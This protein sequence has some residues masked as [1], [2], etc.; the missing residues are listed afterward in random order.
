MQDGYLAIVYLPVVVSCVLFALFLYFYRQV[1]KPY[2]RCWLVAWGAYTVHAALRVWEFYLNFSGPGMMPLFIASSLALVLM[3]AC[4]LRAA[5]EI[6]LGVGKA[7]ILLTVLGAGMLVVARDV[8]THYSAGVLNLLA[9]N[10]PSTLVGTYAGLLM[11]AAAGYLFWAARKQSSL[12]LVGLGSALSLWALLLTSTQ[13]LIGMSLGDLIRQ[14]GH[15]LGALP[16]MLVGLA[17]IVILFE[18]QRRDVLA[19]AE[20]FSSLRY[21]P[22]PAAVD[23]LGGSL[24]R[25]LGRFLD[26]TPGKRAFL[27]IRPEWR[28]HYPSVQ[29]GFDDAPLASF[30][31]SS[32]PAL[33]AELS[34]ARG[35]AFAWPGAELWRL[36]PRGG[37]YDAILSASLA[38]PK[39]TRLTA[40]SLRTHEHDF[41]VIVLADAAITRTGG[42]GQAPLVGLAIQIAL[43]LEHHLAV[44]EA[45]RRTRENALLTEIGQAIAA[46]L[47]EAAL[48]RTIHIELGQ[49]LDNH[50]NFVA[51]RREDGQID[52]HL[53]DIDSNDIHLPNAARSGPF[54]LAEYVMDHG[55]PILIRS[56]LEE[57]MREMGV[58]LLPPRPAKSLCAVPIFLGGEA[59]GVIA[60]LHPEREFAFSERD[61]EIMQTVAGQVSVALENARLYAKERRRSRHFELL[62]RI[63]EIAIAREDAT[64][65]TRQVAEEVQRH[66]GLDLVTIAL[67]DYASQEMEIRAMAGAVPPL[68]SMRSGL[69][70][71]LLGSVARSSE[72]ALVQ[73]LPAGSILGVLPDARSAFCI[74]LYTERTLGV[75]CAESRE[76]TAFTPQD[77]QVLRTLADLLGAALHNVIVFQNMQRQ[78]ITDSLTGVKTRRFFLEALQ[79]EWKRSSRSGRPFAILMLDL[80]NFKQVNDRSGHLEGDL[81]LARVG[82]QIERRSRHSNVVA[83]YGGDEFVVLM[84]ETAI[85]AA[86]V[87]ADRLRLLL[88]ADPLLMQ[89]GV[90]ASMG[91]SAFPLHG[92]T[93]EEILRSADAAMYEAKNAGGNLVMKAVERMENA[94]AAQQRQAVASY[95]DDFLQREQPSLED[96]E[97]LMARL[98]AFSGTDPADKE[99]FLRVA[100]EVLNQ[101]AQSRESLGPAHANDV[102]RYAAM[103]GRDLG[104]DDVTMADLAGAARFHDLG[105]VFVSETILNN[106]GM[107]SEDEFSALKMHPQIGAQ[108]LQLLPGQERASLA[109]RHYHESYDGSGY[110]GGL[111]GEEIPLTARVLC[112]AE[113]FVNMLSERP[114]A[115]AKTLAQ[116]I[117]ELERLSGTRFDPELTRILLRQVVA[118]GAPNLASPSHS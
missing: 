81:L 103:I 54:G 88:S 56:G 51:L 34:A 93:A 82:R 31:N 42:L 47:D 25:F 92:V 115:A 77:V 1:R 63:S 62:N 98:R 28:S 55:N 89:Y 104:L 84:P 112:L 75:L 5:Q 33:L 36:I 17:Q 68:A 111:A 64:D 65:L 72:P 15:P 74:P 117:S 94:P 60:A 67:V 83:R 66:F 22:S 26:M 106:P 44:E 7:A 85:D 35:G 4:T 91:V 73:G 57:R 61:L 29:V 114:F 101:A 69:G 100:L 49:L 96:V 23:Q 9:E 90:T 118:E 105:K 24:E 116:A 41:G 71:G 48:L 45:Q 109:V 102:G 97:T 95:V 38:D 39:V 30:S 50:Y 53:E 70:S 13:L 110:P 21:D 32:A 14:L 8:S 99:G 3:A 18:D 2:L 16:Q 40:L 113:A 46:H 58:S 76:E 80:D 20:A 78:S 86:A 52:F 107:L 10:T 59:A 6:T 87:A 12:G 43:S 11:F 19:S 37:R 27:W 79:Q 108:I